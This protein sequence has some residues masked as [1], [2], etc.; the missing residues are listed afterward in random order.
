MST[1]GARLAALLVPDTAESFDDAPEARSSWVR[2]TGAPVESRGARRRVED[3]G[4]RGLAVA[5]RGR[6]GR[7]GRRRGGTTAARAAGRRSVDVT[8]GE[9][10]PS[11]SSFDGNTPQVAADAWA[12][13][14]VP[15]P[16]APFAPDPRLVGAGAARRLRPAR[17][18]ARGA[19]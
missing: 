1:D 9:P 7:T 8:D 2:S 6:G 18:L 15:A 3:A 16:D 17:R 4:G 10:Q 12:A 13:D 11:C 19:S 14:V 5:D